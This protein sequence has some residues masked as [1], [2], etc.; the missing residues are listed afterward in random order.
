MLLFVL[1]LIY[2]IPGIAGIRIIIK[3]MKNAPE[4]WKDKDG[5]HLDKRNPGF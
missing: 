4:E 5:F 1:L 3:I 2:L